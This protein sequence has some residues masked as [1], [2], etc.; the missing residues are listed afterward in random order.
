VPV[1]KET[2]K[3]LN[4]CI[5]RLLAGEQISVSSEMSD[6]VR[7][8]L[9]LARKMLQT[10]DEP[11]PAFKAQLRA[12]L[13]QRLLQMDYA[14]AHPQKPR[15]LIDWMQ[16][17][18]QE[19]WLWPALTGAAIVLLL[20]VTFTVWQHQTEKTAPSTAS[21][22]SLPS[23]ETALSVKLPARIAP[24]N[25]TYST[26]TSLS[27]ATG[28]VAIYKVQTPDTSIASTTALGRKLG[29]SGE[30]RITERGLKIS[31]VTGSGI[32]SR[33][34][35]VWTNSGAI[36]YGFT[37]SERQYPTASA[38]L[39]SENQAKRIGYEFLKKNDLL[40]LGYIDFSRIE[41]SIIV[42]A[43]NKTGSKPPGYWLVSFP[44]RVDNMIATGPGSKI[45]MN[46]GSNGEILKLVWAFREV[47]P[48]YAGTVRSSE[49]AYQALVRGEGSIDVPLDSSRLVVRQVRL[50]YWIDPLS[51]KQAYSLP[52]YEFKGECLDKSGKSLETFT[53]WIEALN[54]TIR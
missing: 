39:P 6:E 5:D 51:E 47:T 16:Q 20:F 31:M 38:N 11:S 21:L 4:E 13:L 18:L 48:A 32:E 2:E 26:N 46:I 24:S 36:E 53:G 23:A 37:D 15:N 9:E 33:Q 29:L 22:A 40:P 52:V 42:T 14:A 34:L 43:G 1:N 44:Y 28:Q 45:E 7:L 49:S 50:A 30:A 54:P 25:L 27:N 10:R 19:R 3:I 35:T 17:V 8:A 12:R 41:N